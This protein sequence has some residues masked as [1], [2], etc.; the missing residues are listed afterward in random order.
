MSQAGLFNHNHTVIEEARIHNEFHAENILS[1]LSL[2][3]FTESLFSPTIYGSMIIHDSNNILNNRFFDTSGENFVTIR[4]KNVSDEIFEY[5]FV[6]ADVEL[7]IKGDLAD[8]AVVQLS[9]ISKDF[10]KNS[11]T[12]RS[13]GYIN[14]TISEIVS[15]ILKEELSSEI[16][17]ENIGDPKFNT[18]EGESTVTFAFTKIRPFEKINILKQQAFG[19]SDDISSTFIFYETRKGYNF[20]SFEDI[21]THS[22]FNN[23]V[24]TYVYSENMAMNK[25]QN[26]MFLGIKSF[27]PTTR[28]NNL[29]KIVNGMFSS[30]V[31]RFDFN[32]KRVTVKEFNLND[33]Y[34]KFSKVENN[35]DN[36]IKITSKFTDD[37]RENGKYTYFIPWDSSDGRNDMTFKH[38]QYSRPFINMLKENTLNILVDG[39]LG[40]NLGDPINV[41]IWKNQDRHIKTEDYEDERYSGKY[42]IQG[43]NNT[44]YRG[45]MPG[46]WYHDTSIS[47]TRDTTPTIDS[48]PTPVK[49]LNNNLLYIN[50]G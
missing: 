44:V 42:I 46:I 34:S 26:P 50:Q 35:A 20:R 21:I 29:N 23:K 30:E 27:E 45:N 1:M 8:S 33:D 28:N 47:L 13:R 38:F 9:L 43:M 39:N 17:I 36:K 6:I 15:K 16:A 40:L 11:Y 7:E 4:I 41:K 48:T 12:F 31:F 2:Y 22:H 10:F 24:T 3:E 49:N 18:K 32:T 37:V 25:F 14:L 5:T 19:E